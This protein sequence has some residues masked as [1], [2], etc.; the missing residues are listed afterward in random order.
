[1]RSLRCGTH[2]ATR[3]LDHSPPERKTMSLRAAADALDA[4]AAGH[5]PKRGDVIAGAL[6]LQTLVHSGQADR[7]VMDAATGLEAVACGR[8]LNLDEIGRSRAAMLASHVR[9]VAA[10]RD[11]APS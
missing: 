3:T 2:A 7:N 6:T 4:L 5:E 9:D 1:M 10:A 8:S 11:R